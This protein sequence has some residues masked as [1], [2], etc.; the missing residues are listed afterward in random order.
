MRISPLDLKLDTSNP[1]F[2][3]VQLTEADAIKYLLKWGKII[4]LARSIC[5]SGG[6]YIGERIVA[7]D[8][9]DGT[10]TVVEGNRRTCA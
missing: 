4:E 9:H 8:N 5:D 6:L 3:N 1:R 2:L 10:F 7:V